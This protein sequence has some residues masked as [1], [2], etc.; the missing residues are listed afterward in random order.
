[1]KKTVVFTDLDGTL[2][3]YST[4]SFEKAFPALLSLRQR[5]IPLVIC[6][7][8]T[9]SEIEHYREKLENH[10]PFIVENG[11]GIFIPV[12][13]FDFDV[14]SGAYDISEEDDYCVLR[15]GARYSVLRRAI[16]DLRG[17]GFPVRGF[18]DMPAEEVAALTGLSLE[19]AAMAKER[20]FDEPFILIDSGRQAKDLRRAIEQK[21]LTFTEGRFF[22]LLGNSDKGKAVSILISFYRR[23]FGDLTTFGLGDGPNDIPMLREVDQAA[24][25]QRPDGSYDS[26]I[27]LPKLIRAEGIGPGGWNRAV[28]ELIRSV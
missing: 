26:R 1:M 14:K 27:D 4:Y 13:Y 6:S 9:R 10:H 5:G 8:K 19:K 16:G 7:S 12:G 21:G 25:V 17:E 28:E 15:L 23:Q 2:L 18:G 22:H 11:G 20:H 3:D 24:I